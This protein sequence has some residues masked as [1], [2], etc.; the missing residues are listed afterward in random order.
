MNPAD[1]V[2]LASNLAAPNPCSAVRA[3]TSISRSYY[4]AFHRA[5][6]ALSI[7]NAAVDDGP[8]AHGQAPRLLRQSGDPELV[9]AGDMLRDLHSLRRKADYKLSALPEVENR[10][11][12][13]KACEDAQRIF[14][15][16]GK[17]LGDPGRRANAEQAL[18]AYRITV[19]VTPPPP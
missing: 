15:A 7:I 18:A 2:Q 8:G 11:N 3:R 9:V 5:C 17:V 6:E 4:G 12:A 1:F 16:I 13:V 10:A 19:T 14:A